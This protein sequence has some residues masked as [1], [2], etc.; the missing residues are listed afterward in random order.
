MK[1]SEMIEIIVSVMENYHPALDYPEVAEA[2][3]NTITC[4]R[5]GMLPPEYTRDAIE[6]E[7]YDNICDALDTLQAKYR[8][9]VDENESIFAGLD[10]FLISENKWEDE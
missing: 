1:R 7:D 2:I 10:G 3:L 5:F 6:G 4:D 8:P 9:K